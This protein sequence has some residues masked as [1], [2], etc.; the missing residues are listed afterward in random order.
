MLLDYFQARAKV[1]EAARAA[2]TIPE[3]KSAN[4]DEQR[5]AN[6]AFF[7]RASARTE[8]DAALSAL[9]VLENLFKSEEVSELECA[10]S[11]ALRVVG[12]DVSFDGRFL[13]LPAGCEMEFD[14]NGNLKCYE[15]KH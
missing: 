15:F 2:I 5:K 12:G 7:A 10:V 6:A 13:N 1:K 9:A 8:R 4:T 3:A 14:A 11:A